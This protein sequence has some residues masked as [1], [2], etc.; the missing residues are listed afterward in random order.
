MVPFFLKGATYTKLDDKKRFVLPQQLRYGLIENGEL[1]L[2]MG[3]GLGRSLVIY[4]KSEI[5]RMVPYLQEKQHKARY[6]KFLTVFFSNLYDVH[7][8]KLGRVLVPPF[9]Q[10]FAQIK[11]EI[12][13]CGVLDKVE[14]WSREQYDRDLD[15]LLNENSD[16]FAHVFEEALSS[17]GGEGG[18]R[19]CVP[20]ND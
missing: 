10:K 14:I 18:E 9:L 6:R 15:S 12:V 7:C 3:M 5:K 20:A 19:S 8:D 11:S 17:P 4:R 16:L 1:S 2:T 13:I